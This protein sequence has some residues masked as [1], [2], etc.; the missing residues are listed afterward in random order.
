MRVVKLYPCSST[1]FPCHLISTCPFTNSTGLS[2]FTR[3][4][5]KPSVNVTQRVAARRYPEAHMAPRPGCFTSHPQSLLSLP[6]WRWHCWKGQDSLRLATCHLS[7][8]EVPLPSSSWLQTV[9]QPFLTLPRYMMLH[10][11]AAKNL[12]TCFLAREPH[13]YMVLKCLFPLVL[14]G[15]GDA[16]SCLFPFSHHLQMCSRGDTAPSTQMRGNLSEM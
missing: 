13:V 8:Q 7:T 14:S 6:S 3:A 10:C 11:P 4:P 16:P 1:P 9:K 12:T 5:H 15:P 2:V